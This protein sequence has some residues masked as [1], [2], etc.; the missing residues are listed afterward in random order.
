MPERVLDE[1]A[2]LGL[3]LTWML[4]CLALIRKTQS[5]LLD[6]VLQLGLAVSVCMGLA[7]G[8]DAGRLWLLVGYQL[9]ASI[10]VV[11]GN[12]MF[13]RKMYRSSLVLALSLSIVVTLFVWDYCGQLGFHLFSLESEHPVGFVAAALSVQLLSATAFAACLAHSV[14]AGF[15]GVSQSVPGAQVGAEGASGISCKRASAL[16][17]AGAVLWANAVRLDCHFAVTYCLR[18]LEAAGFSAY[19]AYAAGSVAMVALV[20]GAC[21]ALMAYG[22]MRG[23][24]AGEAPLRP[25]LTVL[26]WAGAVAAL[27][28]SFNMACADDVLPIG[29]LWAWAIFAAALGYRLGGQRFVV[30]T[31]TCLALETAIV[32]FGLFPGLPGRFGYAAAMAIGAMHMLTLCGLTG[33]LLYLLGWKRGNAVALAL[34]STVFVMS[35][36]SYCLPI[37]VEGWMLSVCGM[38]CA[39]VWVVLGF[40]MSHDQ[41]RLCGLVVVLLCVAKLVVVDLAGLDPMSR[42]IAYVGGGLICFAVSA[43]YNFATHRVADARGDGC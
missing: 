7:S 13:C 26:E 8:F 31:V 12:L 30:L 25:A 9:V 36:V 32:C 43:L 24:G 20:A 16:L 11:G 17:I 22:R 18:N 27:L 21:L 10:V 39:L 41:L 38:V 3:L 4:M 23:V 15:A 2:A 35:Y 1:L 19:A 33:V 40:A 42:T 34:V 5:L 6:I 14:L 29:F 28:G 37:H